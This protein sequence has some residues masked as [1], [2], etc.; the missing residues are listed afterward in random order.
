VC[1][2]VVELVTDYFENA[3]DRG[4]RERF[5]DHVATCSACVA[6]LRQM[7]ITIELIA[8]TRA[9]ETP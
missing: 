1:Q 4:E 8:A 3:L 5:E 9:D 6:Y 2:E 7:R